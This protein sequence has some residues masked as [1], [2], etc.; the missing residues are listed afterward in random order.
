MV[1]WAALEARPLELDMRRG[2]HRGNSTL[3]TGLDQRVRAR[4]QS[5]RMSLS[6]AHPHSLT[7]RRTTYHGI[8]APKRNVMALGYA[9][10]AF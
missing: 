2:I 5:D 3:V 1:P 7:S 9:A 6:A 8:P 10:S 4:G